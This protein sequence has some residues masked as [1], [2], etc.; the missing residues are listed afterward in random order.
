MLSSCKA[1]DWE[2]T[3]EYVVTN[4][5]PCFKFIQSY[6]GEP[7][8]TYVLR[9]KSLEMIR[10][11]ELSSRAT[12]WKPRFATGVSIDT[13]NVHGIFKDVPGFQM[14][15]CVFYY[16]D[17]ST[18]VFSHGNEKPV[19]RTCGS[20]SIVVDKVFASALR[21]VFQEER[22]VYDTF[23]QMMKTN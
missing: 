14:L 1:G 9:N 10:L 20:F 4:D 2:A 15:T 13:H 21:S 11:G 19:L 12:V 5:V 23:A 6:K 3:T 17:P 16:D 7:T 8:A 22:S 18:N